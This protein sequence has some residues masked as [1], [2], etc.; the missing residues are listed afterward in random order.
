MSR[1]QT[2]GN[3]GS[4]GR[5]S[6]FAGSKRGPG[7]ET[8]RALHATGARIINTIAPGVDESLAAREI[9]KSNRDDHRLLKYDIPFRAIESKSMDLG[10]LTNIKSAAAEIKAMTNDRVNILICNAGVMNPAFAATEDGFEPHFGINYLGHFLLFNELAGGLARGSA[11]NPIS[12]LESCYYPV[13][14]TGARTSTSPS[15][16]PT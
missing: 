12:H 15:C 14:A 3:F 5:R 6:F 9:E 11:A 8:V 7:Q 4:A 2:P 16:L 1:P 10:S 13:S